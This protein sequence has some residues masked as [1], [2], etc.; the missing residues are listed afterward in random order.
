MKNSKN[1]A[2]LFR[3]N[4]RV[5]SVRNLLVEAFKAISILAACVVIAGLAIAM[6]SMFALASYKLAGWPGAVLM[7]LAIC[8][9]TFIGNNSINL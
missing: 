5:Y 4:D 1:R 6:F 7:V 9:F 2:M 3:I 8:G